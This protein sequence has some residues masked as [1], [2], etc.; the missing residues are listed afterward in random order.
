MKKSGLIDSAESG[1]AEESTKTTDNFLL[2]ILAEDSGD[3]VT[4]ITSI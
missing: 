1:D 3:A 4:R 2:A